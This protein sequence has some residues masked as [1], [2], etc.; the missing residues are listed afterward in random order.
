M[1]KIKQTSKFIEPKH[2][3]ALK[4]MKLHGAMFEAIE[5]YMKEVYPDYDCSAIKI[6]V[7]RK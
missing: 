3:N 7:K 1:T 4:Y 6:V 2:I 5:A